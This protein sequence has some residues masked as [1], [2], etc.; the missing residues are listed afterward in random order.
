M[1][2]DLIGLVVGVVFTLGPIVV[3]NVWYRWY[4]KRTVPRIMITLAVSTDQF[5]GAMQ[6]LGAS[7]GVFGLSSHAF[8]ETV[9]RAMEYDRKQVENE[10][11]NRMPPRT[12]N[13][14]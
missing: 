9:K 6:K 4:V 10:A 8:S 1:S 11:R 2:D 5:T 12:G 13:L 14:R 7:L 3:M